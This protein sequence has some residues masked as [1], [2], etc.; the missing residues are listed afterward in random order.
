MPRVYGEVDLLVLKL[1]DHLQMK[2]VAGL[3]REG[4][5]ASQELKVVAWLLHGGCMVVEWWLNGGCMVVAWWL[6]SG[7]M[8]VERW[9]NGG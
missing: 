4:V 1:A 2:V 7:C 5:E 8:V 3:V 9:L 6:H